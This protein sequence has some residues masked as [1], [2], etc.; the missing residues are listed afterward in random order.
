M[1]REQILRTL[2]ERIARPERHARIVKDGLFIREESIDY[3]AKEYCEM[4]NT[5]PLNPEQARYITP[6][7]SIPLTYLEDP[8]FCWTGI[9]I[10]FHP[11]KE[12]PKTQKIPESQG[13]IYSCEFYLSSRDPYLQESKNILLLPGQ[14]N[15]VLI[16]TNYGIYTITPKLL[17]P[18]CT[19][20]RRSIRSRKMFSSKF[21]TRRECVQ[22]L[23]SIL[24]Q[25]IRIRPKSKSIPQGLGTPECIYRHSHGW[26]FAFHQNTLIDFTVSE[27]QYARRAI[28]KK[29]C[30]KEK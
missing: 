10:P 14:P 3:I 15:T 16:S 12:L 21:K 27:E 29:Q 2:I 25:S 13:G 23:E 4:I 28:A 7:F 26:Y 30:K 18:F 6:E 20:I 11:I 17:E 1:G 9:Y 8:Q 5:T 24:R 22:A 19:T